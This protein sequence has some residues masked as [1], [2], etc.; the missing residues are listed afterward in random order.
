[1]FPSRGARLLYEWRTIPCDPSLWP[2]S[3]ATSSHVFPQH[4]FFS[5][6]AEVIGSWTSGGNGVG[7]GLRT[8][9][10]DSCL[11]A[12]VYTALQC[13]GGSECGSRSY[14]GNVSLRSARTGPE[15]P[16]T[17]FKEMAVGGPSAASLPLH[18]SVCL[19]L[20]VKSSFPSSYMGDNYFPL[21]EISLD[22]YL[23]GKRK[24]HAGKEESVCTNKQQCGDGVVWV[25]VSGTFG[26][27]IETCLCKLSFWCGRQQ[28][29]LQASKNSKC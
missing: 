25:I 6:A 3:S 23:L 5:P 14:A 21:C 16:T 2:P 7:G 10:M 8:G 22:T 11:P 13:W 12:D 17:L 15:K 19:F 4:P 24:T 28:K 20:L 29:Q 18:F 1:M 26:S 9:Q 27:L